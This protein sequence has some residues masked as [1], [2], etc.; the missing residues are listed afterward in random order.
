[1]QPNLIDCISKCIEDNSID[2]AKMQEL[3]NS[4]DGVDRLTNMI[5]PYT[6]TKKEII[7]M[8]ITVMLNKWKSDVQKNERFASM[9][10]H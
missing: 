8:F 1:M 10:S 4:D 3:A 6:S 2:G 9:P 7:S 5:I